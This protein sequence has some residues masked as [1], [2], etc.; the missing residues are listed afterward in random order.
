[1]PC[2]QVCRHFSV[3]DFAAAESLLDYV[4]IGAAC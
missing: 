2:R 1:M 4:K 3:V